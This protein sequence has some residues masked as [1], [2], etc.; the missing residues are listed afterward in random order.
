MQLSTALA[1]LF[2]DTQVGNATPFSIALPLKTLPI[3]LLSQDPTHTTAWCM[4]YKIASV[5]CWVTS[6]LKTVLHVPLRIRL[7]TQ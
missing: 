7:L 6:A 5:E 3:A 2:T 4:E 1:Y